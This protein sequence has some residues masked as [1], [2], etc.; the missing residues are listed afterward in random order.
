MIFQQVG[1]KI[2]HGC[3]LTVFSSSEYCGGTNEAACILVDDDKIR[4]IRN[5]CTAFVGNITNARR[6][7]TKDNQV[8]DSCR[9]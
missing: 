6:I 4:T 9:S 7:I 5:R 8:K 1:F 3:L 2:Q